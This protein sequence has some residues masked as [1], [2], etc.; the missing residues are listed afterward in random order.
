MA[1]TLKNYKDAPTRN[2]VAFSAVI[3]VNVKKAG[4]VEQTGRGGCNFYTFPAKADRDSFF[5]AVKKWAKEV[6]REGEIEIE[7]SFI[8]HLLQSQ[9]L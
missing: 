2:G 1:I 8:E 5:R 3:C 7:D 6:G 9:G 4:M